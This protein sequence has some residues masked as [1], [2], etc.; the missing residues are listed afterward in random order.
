MQNQL[1]IFS[2]NANPVLA[3]SI[4]RALGVPMG[5]TSVS[6]ITIV[7]RSSGTDSSSATSCACAVSMPCPRSHLPVN[8]V[9]VPSAPTETHE[10]TCDGS[11][12]DARVSNWLCANY[13]NCPP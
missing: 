1:K 4:A 7:T 11:T 5:E 13:G 10:S 6:H 3:R 8:A 12:C 2:G 9:I